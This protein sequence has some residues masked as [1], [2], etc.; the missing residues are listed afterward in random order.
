MC[1]SKIYIKDTD[2]DTPVIDD[3]ARVINNDEVITVSTLLGEEKDL[4][5]YFI[6]EVNL[7]ENYILLKRRG[8]KWVPN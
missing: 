6:S 7:V 8:D 4:K 3:A 1:L 5:G 2:T